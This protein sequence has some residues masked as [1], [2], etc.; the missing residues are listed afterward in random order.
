MK[1]TR[2]RHSPEQIVKKLRDAEVM[3]SSGKSQVEVDGKAYDLINGT[4][5]LF[6]NRDSKVEVK[7]IT[8]LPSS[9]SFDQA[10]LIKYAHEKQ[11][12]VDFYS[13]EQPSEGQ[14]NETPKH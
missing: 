13:D 10:S 14:L 11:E 5:I 8:S 4:T 9:F 12:V 6:E 2:R 3:L 7:Q 1:K